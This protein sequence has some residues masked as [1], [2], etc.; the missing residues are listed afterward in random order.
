M[1]ELVSKIV[2]MTQAPDAETPLA[3]QYYRDRLIKAE[4]RIQ[5]LESKVETLAAQAYA[6]EQA[7]AECK[8]SL[9]LAREEFRKMK[10]ASNGREQA[11]SSG[12]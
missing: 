3:V 8:R 5:S 4:R 2:C 12:D 9:D 6:A 10:A 7:A 1:S 11:D